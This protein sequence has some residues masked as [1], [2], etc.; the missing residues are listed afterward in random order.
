MLVYTKAELKSFWIKSDSVGD[1][2]ADLNMFSCVRRHAFVVSDMF[3]N[4]VINE[5]ILI[6]QV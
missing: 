5:L 3:E 6:S 4:S 1:R 2:R